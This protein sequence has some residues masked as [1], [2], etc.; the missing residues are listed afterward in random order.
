MKLER[1]ALVAEIVSGIAIVVTLIVL[2]IEVRDNTNAVRAETR[3]SIAE[4]VERITMTVATDDELA[5]LV[6]AAANGE[7]DLFYDLR[8]RAFVT[9]ILRNSEEAYLQVQEGRLETDYFDARL[10][11][12]LFFLANGAT[13]SIY[14]DQKAGG[15]YDRKF[16]TAVDGAIERWRRQEQAQPRLTP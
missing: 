9:A 7:S 11:G 6:T 16:T 13:N 3:Q 1:L 5:E 10:Q 8:V 15:L 12:V 4:R 2:V 14:A